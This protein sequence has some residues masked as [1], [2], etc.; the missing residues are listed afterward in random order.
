MHWQTFKRQKR[1][2][3]YPGW[4]LVIL[5][6]AAILI[7]PPAGAGNPPKSQLDSSLLFAFIQKEDRQSPL[8]AFGQADSGIDEVLSREN[9][10][11][12][13]G[14]QALLERIR[15]QLASE[16]LQWQLEEA[17]TRRM[18]VPEHRPAYAALFENYCQAAVDYVLQKTRLPNPYR[19]IATFE[20]EDGWREAAT[21]EKGGITALLVHNIADVY[22]EEYVFS[23]A[24]DTGPKVMIK[25]S[26]R[27]FTGEVGAYS[28]YLVVGE[29][30]QYEFVRNPYTLWRN[31]A[32]DPL[33]VLIAPIEET[34]H[35]TLRQATE[36]AI[37][38]RLVTQPPPSPSHTN[39]E[40]IVEEW[41]AVE[42]AAVGGLVRQ[43]LPEIM[44]RFL[45]DWP[46]RDVD[47]TLA[48]R[49]HFDKYRYV[50]AGIRIVE[51]LGLEAFLDLYRQDPQAFRAML[52]AASV[53]DA[54][55]PAKVSDHLPV[56]KPA[57]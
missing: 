14:N 2:R 24:A 35:I 27:N 51:A 44:D 30:Q 26:N 45:T 22:T 48:A 17:S 38:K 4:P 57:A 28:S 33:N 37:R 13:G 18:I 7:V 8:V 15:T 21:G 47:A 55:R 39:V 32:D 29:D 53:D 42:E 10:T 1:M 41:L 5:I 31:S 19:S 9:R 43:L 36:Q 46:R 52:D 40:R 16:T 34:L 11:F 23:D 50:D 49:R 3:R 56:A 54:P 6:M 12:L 20:D 25:L